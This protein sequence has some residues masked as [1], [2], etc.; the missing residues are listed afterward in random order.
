MKRKK[1]GGGEVQEGFM[2]AGLGQAL[3]P[4]RQNRDLV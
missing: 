2:A 4:H 3:R 1:E